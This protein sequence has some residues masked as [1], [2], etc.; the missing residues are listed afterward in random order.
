MSAEL[1]VGSYNVHWGRG[2][3]WHK[4][5][6][7]D[8]LAAARAIDTDVLVLQECWVPDEGEADVVRVAR[9]LGYE[10]A[11]LRSLGRSVI[12]PQP[13]LV[14][15][16]DAPDAAAHGVGDWSLAVLTRLP[17]L[18]VEQTQLSQL[19]VDRSNRVVL[20]VRVDL[21]GGRSFTVC[22]THM[23]HLEYGVFARREE[24]RAALPPD[25]EPAVVV[26]DMN[27]WSWCISY[28]APSTWQRVG[29]GR[30]FSSRTPHSRIDHFV[31]SP[32]AEA[33]HT[34]VL[35]HLG[36]DHLPIRGR[37]RVR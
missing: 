36:S 5:P 12:E 20:R 1:T 30:T 13:E 8:V 16:A 34:E 25:E 35:P 23:A 2:H 37:F 21:G 11:G 19:R 6:P 29:R 31:V 28:M 4:Y 18:S 26:G 14:C 15:L 17:I 32:A 3:R 27:M 24:F 33:V 22:G 10:I 9:E 7:F